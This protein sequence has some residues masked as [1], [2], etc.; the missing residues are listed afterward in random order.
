MQPASP[1]WR[2]HRWIPAAVRRLFDRRV[3][4]VGLAVVGHGTADPVGADETR[5]VAGLVGGMLPGV[6]IEAGFLEVIGPTIADALQRLADR[7]CSEVVAAPLLL[8]TAGHARRDVPEAVREGAA[9][10]GLVVRQ[11]AA[12]GCHP[13]L[14]SLSRMRRREATAGLPPVPAE[15]TVLLLVGRG[16]SDP[17]AP[18]QLQEFAAAVL[19]PADDAADGVGRLELGFVAAA[20][21]TLAEAIGAAATTP[22]GA[23]PVRRVIVQP[24]LLFR[25]HVEEQVTA[26]VEE[27]RRRH[28]GI[29]WVQTRRLGADPL[30]ARAVVDRASAVAAA[31][32]T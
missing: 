1:L 20:R 21:P 13:A 32:W 31:A 26:A 28:P 6:A 24:H 30:V 5:A 25:G 14:V 7:G 10:A 9:R 22:G 12:L 27:A 17:S 11:A 23:R 2:Q 18:A 15:E 4:S 19:G 3:P 16:A 8:F 29:E